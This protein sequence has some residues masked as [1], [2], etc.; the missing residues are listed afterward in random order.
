MSEIGW[1]DSELRAWNWALSGVSKGLTAT[2]A[3]QQ[4]RAGGG[5]IANQSWYKF[6][7]EAFG[8]FGKREHIEE[9]PMTYTVPHSMATETFADYREKYIM[10]MELHGTSRITGEYVKHY[11][12]VESEYLLTKREWIAAGI[13]AVNITPGSEPMIVNSVTNFTFYVKGE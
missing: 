8:L 4:Y 11:V 3:L 12:T 13:D 6:Y 5:H 9:I 1:S 7:R 2:S 10:T